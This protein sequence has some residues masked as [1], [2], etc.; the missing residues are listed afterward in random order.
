MPKGLVRYLK[1]FCNSRATFKTLWLCFF[2]RLPRS[3]GE[4]GI[5]WFA[6]IFSFNCNAIDHLATAP[7][8]LWLFGV[9]RKYPR[10]QSHGRQTRNWNTLNG[11]SV[12]GGW[13]LEEIDRFPLK[14]FC[15]TEQYWKLSSPSISFRLPSLKMAEQMLAPPFYF[16]KQKTERKRNCLFKACSLTCRIFN[17]WNSLLWNIGQSLTYL[18][19]TRGGGGS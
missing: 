18:N 13:M 4:P 6:F 15:I 8:T 11:S 14:L 3:G 10:S 5:F 12:G 17:W 7:P 1:S 2:K 16:W 9:S 19:L